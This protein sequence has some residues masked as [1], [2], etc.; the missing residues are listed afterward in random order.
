MSNSTT[1]SELRAGGVTYEI[2]ADE[3]KLKADLDKA[4]VEFDRF[5]KGIGEFGKK[6][7]DSLSKNIA[8][9]LVAALG[10]NTL[11][12]ALRT[13]SGR[14]KEAAA[15]G[16]ELDMSD[17]GIAVAE[18]FAEGLRSVPVAG[19]L[20]EMLAMGI[21]PLFGGNLFSE[22]RLNRI[23][24]AAEDLNKVR[25]EIAELTAQ[26]KD[27]GLTGSIDDALAKVGQ[28]RDAVDRGTPTGPAPED[29]PTFATPGSLMWFGS[30]LRNWLNDMFHGA[31]PDFVGENRKRGAAVSSEVEGLRAAIFE[32]ARNR[33]EQDAADAQKQVDEINGLISPEEKLRDRVIEMAKRIAR[34]FADLGDAARGQELSKGVIDRFDQGRKDKN[35]L[36][37]ETSI[38]SMQEQTF[39]AKVGEFQALRH[40]LW[41]TPGVSDA[42]SIRALQALRDLRM[43]Q[44]MAG[45]KEHAFSSSGTFAGAD[46]WAKFPSF[47]GGPIE[48]LEKIQQQFD[49]AIRTLHNIANGQTWYP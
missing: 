47:K 29:A 2:G 22:E 46:A 24:R 43:Q 28:L 8:K 44:A 38:S 17:V 27:R 40:K 26:V 33:A 49:E 15:A 31:S 48:A 39:N 7:G 11:D 19:P 10:V 14:L 42:Q 5:G 1:P 36:D 34:A 20:G 13:L 23:R 21:D 35:S 3:A 12:S 45:L 37:V 9:G 30:A 18:S 25:G 6:W 32:A 41:L 4:G 16:R